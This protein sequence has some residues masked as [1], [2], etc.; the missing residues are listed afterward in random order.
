MTDVR[1][2]PVAKVALLLVIAFIVICSVAL[3]LTVTGSAPSS[4]Q[5]TPPQLGL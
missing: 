5:L 3:L 1:L 2:H 4:I